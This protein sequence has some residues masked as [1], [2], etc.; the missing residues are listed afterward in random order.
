MTNVMKYLPNI[1]IPPGETILEL[2]RTNNMTQ[3]ELAIR[4]DMSNK[5][6]NQII[7]GKT[8]ITVETA[9]K[10]EK[11]FD[12]P[13]S[14]WLN[15]EADYQETK[16]RINSKYNE[17]EKKIASNIPYS[18]MVKLGWVKKAKDIN[19]KLNN[20]RYYFRIS[21]LTSIKE[22][23]NAAYRVS[24]PQKA[25]PIAL[26]AWLERGEYLSKDIETK[27]FSKKILKSY[28]PVFKEM[29]N[30]EPQLFFNN[31]RE[32]LSECG[33]AFVLVPNISRTYA[34]GAVKWLSPEKV[35]LQLSLRYKYADI[36]WFSFFHEIGHVLLHSKKETYIEYESAEGGVIEEEADDFAKDNLIPKNVLKDFIDKNELTIESITKFAKTVNI[37]PG[38]V[39]G[40]LQHDHFI[41][42]NQL[43]DLR[44]KYE[45]DQFTDEVI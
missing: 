11:I 22:V 16:A 33:I 13:A 34:H 3:A 35:L 40:R 20:L 27:K 4:M 30:L 43:S 38:I 23:Y 44:K 41:S 28:L 18:E 45:Y 36:F 1:A 6:I 7:K 2:L 9:L 39:V 37:D 25:S 8:S 29:T 21:N 26:A 15:L 10:L 19:D 14:F 42:Y 31:L 24:K 17:D 12:L 32:K 5:H